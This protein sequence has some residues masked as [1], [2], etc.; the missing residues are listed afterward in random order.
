MT[1][2]AK[3][4]YTGV[5]YIR[6]TATDHKPF[7]AWQA[8][9]LPEFVKEQDAGR[10][11]HNRWMLGYY[12]RV[13]EH[14]FLGKNEEGCMMQM[15]SAL[16]WSRWYDA[17]N[18]SDRCTRLDLQVTWPTLD[19]PGEYI[20][21]MYEVGKLRPKTEG[22]QPELQITDTPE[23]AKMLTS[24]SR[25]S[26]VYGRMYDKWRESK[27]PEYKQC[28]RWEIEV[29]GQAARDLNAYM[30]VNKSEAGTTRAIVKEFWQKRGMTP[31]WETFEAMEGIPPMKRSKTDETKIAWL[32]AQV[33]PTLTKLREHG[34]LADS[35]RALFSQALTDEQ[36]E[37]LLTA[38]YE[39][40]GS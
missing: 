37:R 30:R 2:P 27:M 12:G 6:L 38:L 20:R 29:K 31:F 40:V 13:G 1:A 15:S 36:V 9:L 21:E 32:A 7:S 16:A 24:G 4:V 18:H 3:L 25:Q 39:E 34:R 11:V 35:I 26:E 8:I 23:G 22:K 17:G 14:C 5:D 19:D 10:R 28:V 33:A